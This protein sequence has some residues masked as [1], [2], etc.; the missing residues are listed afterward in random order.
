[1]PEPSNACLMRCHPDGS[2]SEAEGSAVAFVLPPTSRDFPMADRPLLTK[3][4]SCHPERSAS[5]G[6]LAARAQEPDQAI[7]RTSD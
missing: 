6:P 1:M 3:T 4:L 2:H 5:L 7:S